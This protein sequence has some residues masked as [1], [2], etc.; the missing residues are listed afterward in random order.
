MSDLNETTVEDAA[1]EYLRELGYTTAFGPEI[2][3]D[4][5]RS[6]R[7]AYDSV[8]LY[9]RLRNAIARINP[10]M[11]R[12]MIEETIKRLERAENMRVH[13]LLRNG[14]PVERRDAGGNARTQLVHLIDF[15]HPE[16]NDW[17]A[18]NQFTIIGGRNRR[19]DVLVFLNGI[20]VALFELKNL[21]DTHATLKNGWNQ[22]QTY[23]M[24]IPSIFIPN[25]VTVLSDG[26]SAAMS[27]FSGAFEHY[28]PWKTM[29]GREVV[30][31]RSALEVLIKGVFDQTRFLDI[32]KNFVVFS[33][34]GKGLV[35]RVA[36]Y[37]QY[38]AVNAA[39]ESTIEASDPNNDR[40]GGIV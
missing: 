9:N 25:L 19:P 15:E 7:I 30:T 35:K 27:S 39:V 21:A 28:A 20:P 16:N 32:L 4:G 29:D 13:Q 1:M 2:A 22:V 14:V 6:E 17:L 40:R 11:D 12:E 36:K 10:G 26:M 24:D 34:E 37:H 23:R 5:D 3:P 18:V 31:N 33:D 38:W 8:Y